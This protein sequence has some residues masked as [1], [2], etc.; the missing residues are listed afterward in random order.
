MRFCDLWHG[1]ENALPFHTEYDSVLGEEKSKL[2][3]DTC[4]SW[5]HRPDD[6]N[7]KSLPRI[8]D[9]ADFQ[10]ILELH[11]QMEMCGHPNAVPGYISHLAS[12][13]GQSHLMIP[14]V[15]I[16]GT[17]P[18]R[19]LR[20]EIGMLGYGRS[21]PELMKNLG[22][23][24]RSNLESASSEPQRSILDGKNDRCGPSSN[25]GTDSSSS[26]NMSLAEHVAKTS[27]KPSMHETAET[28]GV[29]DDLPHAPQQIKC[30][31]ICRYCKRP[32]DTISLAFEQGPFHADDC[33]RFVQ[34]R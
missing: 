34:Q 2:L 12:F 32:A 23:S 26:E 6:I 9:N 27:D 31:Y 29:L 28:L 24:D 1:G 20:T 7:R 10:Q 18:K 15:Y 21:L 13:T 11:K 8:M 33:P 3:L 17:V 22:S 16:C 25:L 4:L 19:F 30:T 5:L 14:Y